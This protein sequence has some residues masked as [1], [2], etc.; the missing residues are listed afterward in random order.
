MGQRFR[1]HIFLAGLVAFSPL[2]YA[3]GSTD[4]LD[5]FKSA[6]RA[7]YDLKER[8]FAENDPDFIVDEF[9]SEDVFSVD[10]E[11]TLHLPRSGIRT[12]GPG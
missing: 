11:G 6:I 1:L 2:A 3:A 7:R 9:Y 8:A 10:N 4:D 12:A 5:E